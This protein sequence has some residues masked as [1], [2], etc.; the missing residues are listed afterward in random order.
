MKLSNIKPHRIKKFLERKGFQLVNVVG[1]HFYYR[2]DNNLVCVVYH[3]KELGFKSI[4]SII[5]Q[6]GI[7]KSEWI[8]EL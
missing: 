4:N 5:R 7:S 3:N 8:K 2:K 6:S 1:S